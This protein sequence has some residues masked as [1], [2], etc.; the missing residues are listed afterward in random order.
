MISAQP[1]PRSAHLAALILQCSF[2]YPKL[3]PAEKRQHWKKLQ[4]VLVQWLLTTNGSKFTANPLQFMAY[5]V[6]GFSAA[7]W[8][9]AFPDVEAPLSPPLAPILNAAPTP[10]HIALYNAQLSLYDAFVTTR[11]IYKSMLE[12]LYRGEIDHLAHEIT[13]FSGVSCA[14]MHAAA[15]LVH[16]RLIADD[17]TAYRLAT[18]LKADR[19]LTAEQN[20][21]LFLARDKRLTD[22][23]NDQG[24]SQGER[25]HLFTEFV[26]DMAPELAAIVARYLEQTDTATRTFNALL[27]AVRLG[28]SRLPT[29]PLL[30][31]YG[32]AHVASADTTATDADDYLYPDGEL[33]AYAAVAPSKGGGRP[34]N[35]PSQQKT[36]ATKTTA[37]LLQFY[38]SA[39]KSQYCFAHGHSNHLG[40][41][42]AS[43]LNNKATFTAA[44]I[45][46]IKPQYVKGKLQEVDGVLPNVTFKGGFRHDD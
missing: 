15:H 17:Y 33:S 2:D 7:E 1:D 9:S 4:S 35:M 19:S 24:L 8:A 40:K 21:I 30:S 45:N 43:M 34:A 37:E 20:I 38:E 36:K 23:G 3:T 41:R 14:Q 16:G 11:D 27:A 10:A 42:C 31:A 39:P 28:L 13:A 12:Y 25:L 6:Y 18:K 32:R 46:L 44:Q 29:Q 26:T 22:S 5:N